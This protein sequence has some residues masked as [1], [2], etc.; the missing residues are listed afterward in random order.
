MLFLTIKSELFIIRLF[1]PAPPCCFQFQEIHPVHAAFGKF[2]SVS[3]SSHRVQ[4]KAIERRT[5]QDTRNPH[6]RHLARRSISICS[7]P[8][9][10]CQREVVK[11]RHGRSMVFERIITIAG[12]W[13]QIRRISARVSDRT[14]LSI[15]VIPANNPDHG[16]GPNPRRHAR[17]GVKTAARG[18]A[19]P[20]P[21]PLSYGATAARCRGDR[22]GSERRPPSPAHRTAPVRPNRTDRP[23]DRGS[24]VI[25]PPP[26]PS[27]F[28]SAPTQRN[29][30]LNSTPTEGGRRSGLRGAERARASSRA[31]TRQ[32]S[33]AAAERTTRPRGF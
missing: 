14:N 29:S 12:A 23:P 33:L 21:P 28:R 31:L 27:W 9:D 25:P 15:V 24:S 18:P 5:T 17:T 4:Q 13:L 11:K 26:P 32:P 19:E 16:P 30:Q 2:A 22:C 3:G 10:A 6:R 1:F 8:E 7:T 20:N